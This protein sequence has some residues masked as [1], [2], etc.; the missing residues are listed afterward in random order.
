MNVLGLDLAVAKAGAARLDDAGRIRTWRHIS[1][2][3]PT[4]A[5]PSD[6]AMR[7]R[8]VKQWAFGRANTATVLAVI[9]ELPVGTTMGSHDQRAAVIHGVVEMFARA[10]VPV[11]LIN[12][13]TL[14]ARIAHGKA[15][16]DEIRKAVDRLYPRQG[17]AGVTDDEAD[18]AGLAILGACRLAAIHGPPWKGPWLEARSLALV[19]A[20]FRWPLELQTTPTERPKVSLPMFEVPTR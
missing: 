1:D 13:S 20:G 8:A 19:G 15:T 10:E 3:L 7:I 9:E 17:L 16:K 2:T 4:D 18:A 5:T 6:V 12:P 14:K 11:A